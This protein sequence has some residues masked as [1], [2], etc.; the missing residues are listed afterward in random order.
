MLLDLGEE[1]VQC[2]LGRLTILTI[3]LLNQSKQFVPLIHGKSLLQ[4]TLERA[5]L[6]RKS[7]V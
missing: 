3:F 1:L 7:V 4:L 2:G 5:A 6:D